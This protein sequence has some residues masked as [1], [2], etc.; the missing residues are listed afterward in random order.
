MTELSDFKRMVYEPEIKARDAEIAALRKALNGARIENSK[1]TKRHGPVEADEVEHYESCECCKKFHLMEEAH[2]RLLKQQR[3]ISSQVNMDVRCHCLAC[4]SKT[5]EIGL[6]CSDPIYEQRPEALEKPAPVRAAERWAE[7]YYQ[8]PQYGDVKC[9]CRDDFIRLINNIQ[10]DALNSKAAVV[11]VPWGYAVVPMEATAENGMKARFMGEY[12]I[13]YTGYDPDSESAYKAKAII[14]WTMLKQI[15]REMVAFAASDATPPS[16]APVA[17]VDAE[18]IANLADEIG[19]KCFV[20]NEQAGCSVF[21]TGLCADLLKERLPSTT[22]ATVPSTR[23]D[24]PSRSATEA[25]VVVPPL[26]HNV[27]F[28]TYKNTVPVQS[29]WGKIVTIDICMI[30]EVK[31]LWD[32]EIETVESCCGHNRQPGYIAVKEEYRNKM[33][34]LG[35][36]PYPAAPHCYLSK[37]AAA[38]TSA[39]EQEVLIP[40]S[41]D[42]FTTEQFIE[43]FSIKSTE[44]E[45]TVKHPPLPKNLSAS[46]EMPPAQ[47]PHALQSVTDIL[48]GVFMDGVASGCNYTSQKTDIKFIEPPKTPGENV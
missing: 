41:D 23:G 1:F 36:Q 37:S 15:Y 11:V 45:L 30:P 21:R 22:S 25:G 28:G 35:Y 17:G 39:V 3:A 32:Q 27:D 43:Y 48:H 46:S 24:L 6:E 19:E 10:R 40:V 38:S 14:D 9:L 44:I 12:H 5:G 8:G 16:S 33:Q 18:F 2:D 26:C 34:E 42:I 4:D 20:H 29:P 47:R 13:P 31:W 7:E